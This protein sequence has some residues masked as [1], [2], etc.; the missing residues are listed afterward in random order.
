MLFR[1]SIAAGFTE[2]VVAGAVLVLGVRRRTATPWIATLVGTAGVLIGASLPIEAWHEPGSLLA[3]AVALLVVSL[4]EIPAVPIS[5]G[6]RI[7]MLVFAAIAFLFNVPSTVGHFA[8]HGGIVTGLVVWAIAATVVAAAVSR[9][10]EHPITLEVAGGVL[11]VA[12]AAITGVQHEGFA[13][14]IGRA[15]V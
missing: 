7:A 8:E 5:R 1:S 14:E 3:I 9:R 2:L 6:E 11:L 12:G 4:V 15:H 10:I 13:T